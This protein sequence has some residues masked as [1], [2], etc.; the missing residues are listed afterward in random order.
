MKGHSMRKGALVLG[1]LALSAVVF[2]LYQWFVPSPADVLYVHGH[3]LTMDEAFSTAEALAVRGDRIVGVGS[4]A[5]MRRKFSS[6]EEVDLG[7]KTVLPG[8]IDAHAHFVSL[9]I[10]RMTVDLLGAPTPDQAAARVQE[11]VRRSEPGQWVRGRG[12]NQN[13]WPSKQFPLHRTLDR[14]APDNPVVLGRVDGHALWVNKRAL[15]IAGITRTTPD[16]PGGRIVRDAAGDPTGVLVDNAEQ[17]IA[18]H[19]PPPTQKEVE[20]SMLLA[21]Q[22]CLS[23]GLTG[24]H[25]MGVDTLDLAAYKS[26]IDSDQLRMRIYA[27]VGGPGATWEQFKK[28]GP[29]LGYGNHRLTVRAIK[30]YA[31][32]ALG[33]RGAALIDPYADDPANRGLTVTGENQLEASVAEAMTHGFQVCTHAIGDRANNIVLNVYE[34]ALQG[35]PKSDRRL[36]VEHAQVLHRDDIGRFAPLGIIPSM[37]PT[38]CTSDMYWAE[39]R[40]GPD[41]IRGAY[42][43]R[44]LLATGVILPCGSDFPVEQPNPLLG[45][46][47]AVTR[48]DVDGR[49]RSAADLASAFE[50]SAG[51]I[52]D[53]EAF[54]HG[55]YAGER[56][57]LREVLRGYTTWAANAAFEEDLKGSLEVGKLADFI[58]LSHTP[59]EDAPEG[60]L[61]TVVESTFIGGRKVFAR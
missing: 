56:M 41:R 30:L 61:T 17:L 28:S 40:L 52:V 24:V 1:L 22:E 2:L 42:A 48:R 7:G 5:E 36:R 44:S 60:I 3:V 58:V 51:G 33:S 59:D 21:Q 29:L 8:L 34:R 13:L 11:R 20:E 39:A 4:T 18:I 50:L 26:L 55:W 37:Q 9:G 15:E 19:I 16:P 57:T 43:W 12:W 47:A 25:D 27:A 32:G 23:L 10:A 54:E 49:P 46:Y 35:A 31:D 45:I 6:P 53:P 38:H 14:V